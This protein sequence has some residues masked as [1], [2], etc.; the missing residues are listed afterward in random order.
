MVRGSFAIRSLIIR[1]SLCLT[2][3]RSRR[4]KAEDDSDDD[5]DDSEEDSEE[6]ES[7]EETTAATAAPTQPEISRA[8]RRQLKKQGKTGK[9]ADD[10]EDTDEDPIMANPNITVGKKMNISDLSAPRELSRRERYV[11]PFSVFS[12][13]MTQ[14]QT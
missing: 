4:G 13:F 6:E 10:G 7:E 8:E 11:R 9:Q 14:Y 2:I 3:F 5:D 12:P 1:L